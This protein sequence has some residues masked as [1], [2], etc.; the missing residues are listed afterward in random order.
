MTFMFKILQICQKF[1]I[2][3]NLMIHENWQNSETFIC[4]RTKSCLE[5]QT[6]TGLMCS[7]AESACAVGHQNS[8]TLFDV[9]FFFCGILF[10]FYFL[11]LLF[12]L[13]CF[14]ELLNYYHCSAFKSV[15]LTTTFLLWK[16]DCIPLQEKFKQ[17]VA[18]EMQ[19]LKPYSP[20]N[21]SQ[22]Q[23]FILHCS[24]SPL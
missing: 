21:L 20:L 3:P 8:L 7:K 16:W 23:T 1:Q 12:W 15:F 6:W 13:I 2:A 9:F 24:G 18:V 19:Q 22:T 5:L 14:E 4:K 17:L 10:Y 11:F